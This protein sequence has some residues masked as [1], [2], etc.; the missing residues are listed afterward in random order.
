[1]DPQQPRRGHDVP[2][3][4]GAIAIALGLVFLVGTLG[5]LPPFVAD[6]SGAWGRVAGPLALVIVGV[7]VIVAARRGLPRPVLPDKARR[8]YRSRHD[9]VAA[10][11]CGGLAEY[12]RVD[13]VIV[14]L[15]FVLAALV[16]GV[17]Q[18]AIAYALLVW[19]MPEQPVAMPTQPAQGT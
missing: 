10:G 14:R 18:G 17:V 11:V 3:I 5:L 6:W 4:L 13:P 19:A 8:L 7:I 2:Q 9:R 1:M 12:L 15:L 16:F